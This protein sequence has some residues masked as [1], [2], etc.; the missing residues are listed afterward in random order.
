MK[1]NTF[2]DNTSIILTTN[3]NYLGIYSDFF[4]ITV[5]L[6]LITY[7]VFLEYKGN[8]KF[9][10]VNVI[11]NISILSIILMLL[12]LINESEFIFFNF[13]FLLFN[14]YFTTSIKII[15]LIFF[16]IL[17]ILSINYFKLEKIYKYEYYILIFLSLLGLFIIINS[18]DLITMYLG[19]E[20]QSLCFYILASFKFYNNFSS[21][22]GL[23]YFILG[24][25]SS[26]LLLFGCSLLYGITGLTNFYELEIFLQYTNV[27]VYWKSLLISMFFI[28]IGLLFKLSAAPFHM[29]AIDVYEGSPTLVT[30]FFS[31]IPKIGIITLLIKFFFF[32]FNTYWIYF[33]KIVLISAFLSLFI[34]TFSALNQ[35]K[36]KRLLA[37][38]GVV[39]VGFLLTGLSINSIQGFYSVYFYLIIYMVLSLT[40]FA[41]LLSIYKWTNLKKIKNISE[42]V[43]LFKAN[44]VLSFILALTLFSVAGIPPLLGFYSKLYVFIVGIQAK[45]Y[46]L[47]TIIALMSVISAFYYLRIIKLIFFKN[48]QY[49]F[50]LKPLSSRN[51]LII[52]FLFLINFFFLL[53]PNFCV[54]VL[55]N[56]LISI[57]I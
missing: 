3:Y 34:G 46:F 54:L 24:A 19:I 8:Y 48:W 57:F 22:A 23:K 11:S 13:S 10:L 29:W 30:A 27:N 15:I 38:S 41:F 26:A 21:E 55:H 49:F 9:I 7:F 35:L 1:L 18:Y 25:F 36:L 16:L 2:F 20:L 17:T 6:L 37:Y 39:H 53:W 4:L 5:I 32:F 14:N 33:S 50:L 40:L 43:L 31:I 44:P 45:Y 28:L 51:S 52:A 42:V 56:I 47:I 12:L